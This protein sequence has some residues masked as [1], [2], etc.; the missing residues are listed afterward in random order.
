LNSRAI[1]TIL[2]ERIG[3]TQPDIPA[4][5]KRA[6]LALAAFVGL[7]A[8]LSV[9]G[10]A[11]PADPGEIQRVLDARASEIPG[12]GIVAAVIDDRKVTFYTAGES[13]TQRPL[14]EWTLFEIG[15]VTKTFTAT[16]LAE[17]VLAGHVQLSDPVQKYLPSSVHVPTYEG[18]EIT[19]LDLA[20]QHSGLPRLPTNLPAGDL[21]PYANY[22]PDLL[23]AFLNS[24]KLTRAPGATFEYSNLGVGL[25]GFALARAN[26][27]TYEAMVR[28][29]V[30]NPLH[31]NGSAIA[32]DAQERARF[33][34]G[35]DVDG[36]VVPSWD[37]GEPV[38]GAGGIRSDIADMA[39][40]LD[41][42][43]GHGPLAKTML[44]AQEPR[45]TF[46]GHHIGLVWWINDASGFIDHGGDTAGYHAEVVMTG[47]RKHGVV[48]LS[49]GPL[50]ADLASHILDT[51][52]PV[53]PAQA[54]LKL[55]A[56]QLDEYV[57]MYTNDADKLTYVITRV[58][59]Q[60]QAKIVGQPSAPIYASRPDHFYYK[61]VIAYI[62]FV[63]Q[64]GNVVGLILTQ[65]GNHIPVYR[66]GADGKPL[67]DK[68]A[69]GYP[70]VVTPDSATLQSHV[71][72]YHSGNLAFAIT[73]VNGRTFAKLGDQAAYEVYPSAND[74]FFYKI[75]DAQITF[76]RDP[77]GKVTGLALVQNGRAITY[78]KDP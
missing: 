47:D 57:G 75:V 1:P 4:S 41:A 68:L 25:L 58:G 76:Q 28:S 73:V 19:L 34:A 6:R 50:V 51:T 3:F 5:M 16:V 62:E 36:R 45:S 39:K 13:G 23:Y 22:T 14:D 15:S 77:S 67:V 20:T 59:T 18:R 17:M 2:R 33:V 40:Y 69:P 27:A 63:R 42:A 32:L 11:A 31:M 70:P 21:N 64:G 9:A 53:T 60:L 35:H 54:S 30:W 71:G 43:M 8:S 74:A 78:T 44:F 12:T 72:T 61:S 7:S 55:S 48:L 37:F 38:V 66:L 65:S 49:N 52:Y 56:A 10:G 26:N 24:Y 46:L 29:R